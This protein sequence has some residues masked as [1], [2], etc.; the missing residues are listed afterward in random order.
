MVK[1]LKETLRK[2]AYLE[3]LKEK[4]GYGID[5]TDFAFRRH[6]LILLKGLKTSFDDMWVMFDNIKLENK[7]DSAK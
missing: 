6:I 5:A 3:K 4:E 2:L 7:E 1:T